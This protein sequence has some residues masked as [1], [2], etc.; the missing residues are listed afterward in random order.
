[1]KKQ[2]LIFKTRKNYI[3]K[4]TIYIFQKVHIRKNEEQNYKKHLVPNN[5]IGAPDIK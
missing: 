3:F 2:F 5:I 1:M 4:N